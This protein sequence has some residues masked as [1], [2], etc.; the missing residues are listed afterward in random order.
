MGTL[1]I[2]GTIDVHQFWP[3]GTSDADTVKLVVTDNSF[4]FKGTGSGSYFPTSVF[5]DASSKGQGTKPVVHVNKSD[6]V[7]SITIR[8]EHLD[9]CELH[10]KAA[11][12]PKSSSITDDMRKKYNSQNKERRQNFGESAAF[13]LGDYL[14]QFANNK[15]LI[16]AFFETNVDYPSDVVDTYGRFIGNIIINNKNINLW[17]V[18]NGWAF[19]TFYSSA[20]EQEIQKFLDAWKKGKNIN[21]KTARSAWQPIWV[22]RS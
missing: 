16:D 22:L 18:E 2:K 14:K 10:Y 6:G 20:T 17:L 8:V 21:P 12:L 13:A 5:K 4:E 7:K 11:P 15:G 1:R 3:N 9:A 19:P